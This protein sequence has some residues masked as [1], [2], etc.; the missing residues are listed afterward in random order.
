MIELE[1]DLPAHVV[2][3]TAHD[4]VDG[5]DYDDV[6]VPAVEAAT[7][8]DAKARLLYV[9]ADDF[10]G[11]TA[12]AA[13]DDTRIG[14]QHWGDFERIGLVSDHQA[15]RGLV[16]SMGFLIPGEVRVFSLDDLDRAR[17]WLLGD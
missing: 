9:L 3:A 16:R 14:V 2:V 1:P 17:D 11:Y 4:T 8:G 12:S 15:Y 13:L 10:E 7:A 5:H 6:L